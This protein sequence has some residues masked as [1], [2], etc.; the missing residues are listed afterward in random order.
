MP[1]S[2]G[3][4]SAPATMPRLMH[5]LAVAGAHVD[6]VIRARLGLAATDYQALKHLL[7]NSEP[8]GPV[9]LGRLLGIS[10]GSATGLVDRLQR[11]G[12]VERRPHPG[13]RRRQTLVVSESTAALIARHLRPLTDAVIEYAS[14]FP[15]SERAAIQR[16]LAGVLPLARRVF[17]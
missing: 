15:P 11:D 10:S 7:G 4:E 16:F 3:P 2:A 9:G 17:N 13:D 1:A 14:T 6:L 5:D 12:H 8:I